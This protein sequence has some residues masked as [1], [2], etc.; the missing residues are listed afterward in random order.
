MIAKIFKFTTLAAM[1]LGFALLSGCGDDITSTNTGGSSGDS[2]ERI[3]SFSSSPADIPYG[4]ESTISGSVVDSAGAGLDGVQVV[5]SVI[6]QEAGY[7][8]PAAVETG[9]DGSFE[10]RFIPIDTGS[11]EIWAATTNQT[12]ANFS[13]DIVMEENY[14]TGEWSFDF[15]STP[16]FTLADGQDVSSIAVEILDPDGNPIANGVEVRLE[17]G[18]RFTDVDGDGYF[19]EN[20]DNVTV[21]IN[22]N[23]IWDRVGTVPRT[24]VSSDGQINFNYTAGTLSGLIY[25]RAS[26]VDNGETSSGEFPMVL[27][28]SDEIASIDLSTDRSEIQVKA[29]GGIEFTNLTAVC[30]DPYGNKVQSELPVKFFIVYGPGGGERFT[31]SEYDSTMTSEDTMQA[32]TNVVG[33]ASITFFSGIKSGTA[34]LQARYGDVYSNATLVTID[35]GPAADMSVGVDPCNIRGWDKVNVTANVVVIVNDKYGNPVADTTS[36]YFWT[37][38]GM[39]VAASTTED[40]VASSLYSSGDPRNDGLAMIYCETAGGTV[41]DSTLLIV[42]GPAVYV[43]AYGYATEMNA[44]G[45]D[46]TDIW[47]DGRDI[48]NNFM[49]EGTGVQILLSDGAI[50]SGSLS[51][52]CYSSLARIRY[53]SSTLTR[54]YV[55]SVP[56]NGIGRILNGSVQVGGVNGPTDGIN[57]TLHTGPANVDRSEVKVASTA[58]PGS[59]EPV[60]VVIKDRAGNPLGGH[61]ITSSASMGSISPASATTNAYGEVAFVYTA[62]GAIGNAYITLEDEDPG[63]GGI[64]ITKKIKI[65]ITD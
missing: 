31:V 53:K 65:D 49:V 37:D 22:D 33:E 25:I 50:L 55:Y 56:D 41:S 14:Q 28:P 24:A 27:R 17:A 21:D 59:S 38:E 1:I 48:N 64:I 15:T 18:E 46:Y 32:V 30:Y 43:T 63:Y 42:S 58:A 62:P 51:D 4:S 13:A 12:T 2:Y 7:F 29:T 10:A 36:V 26:V 6:P 23:G 47:V 54:D 39:V 34:M 52:G 11:V 45:E 9:S 19:T 61:L 5:L 44:D 8:L 3:V 20:V 16:S 60:N 40:G 35:A 57:I